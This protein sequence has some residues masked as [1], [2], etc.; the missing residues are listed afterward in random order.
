[1][2]KKLL[3]VAATVYFM[4]SGLVFADSEQVDTKQ[5]EA[6]NTSEIPTSLKR[7]IVRIPDFIYGVQALL[8]IPQAIAPLDKIAADSVKQI[9]ELNAP[10]AK[11]KEALSALDMGGAIKDVNINHLQLFA[12]LGKTALVGIA[13][14]LA[15]VPAGVLAEGVYDYLVD[16]GYVNPFDEN[17]A[18][19]TKWERTRS[20]AAQK[21]RSASARYR[22]VTRALGSINGLSNSLSKTMMLPFNVI[23]DGKKADTLTDVL[24]TYTDTGASVGQFLYAKDD[25]WGKE[26][27]P[28][29][30][31]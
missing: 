16:Q 30:T 25:I 15:L 8:A 2:K 29:E 3:L 21:L 7:M 5:S 18:N 10:T 1:M 22:L 28:K 14:L 31:V 17:N 20:W 13:G 27:E 6:A 26:E 23:M 11:L 4:H 19:E 12:S 24:Y 9:K